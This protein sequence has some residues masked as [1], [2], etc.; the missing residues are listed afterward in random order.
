MSTNTATGSLLHNSRPLLLPL[1]V[2]Y[3]IKHFDNLLGPLNYSAAAQTAR[4]HNDSSRIEARHL[5]KQHLDRYIQHKQ[6]FID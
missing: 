2:Q 3:F 6:N 1:A 4:Q 5:S